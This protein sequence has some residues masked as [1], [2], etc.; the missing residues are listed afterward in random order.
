MN[1]E[2]IRLW[3]GK[4][5][6]RG[7]AGNVFLGVLCFCFGVIVLFLT[8]WF[9]YAVIFIGWMGISAF[10]ELVTGKALH[11][12]HRARMIGSGVF[13]VLLFVQHFRTSRWYWG[14]YPH[15]GYVSAPGLQA[16]AGLAGGLAFMLAYPG[17]SAN[18]VADILL[19]GPRLVMGASHFVARGFRLRS[20]DENGCAQLLAFLHSRNGA[21]HF[22]ELQ[23]AGWD[24]WIAQ[25]RY[26][27]GVQFLQKGLLLS[28]E[29]R[30]EL[31]G[32]P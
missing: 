8:F 24:E 1:P 26:I 10:S 12:S 25:L 3:L 32:L 30:A 22:D 15:R 9:T 11:L 21:V 4:K 31:N 20:L 2:A 19:S 17:A 23:S 13:I 6:A 7:F 18:M 28:E 14:E 16:R 27:D 29:L 5:K